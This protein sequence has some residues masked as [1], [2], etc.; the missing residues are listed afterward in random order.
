MREAAET[1][2]EAEARYRVAPVRVGSGA[3]WDEQNLR[4]YAD[5]WETEDAKEAAKQAE[6]NELAARLFEL[7]PGGAWELVTDGGRN[8]YRR[9]A[10]KLLDAGYRKVEE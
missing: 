10:Q 2:K 7:H 5:V 9:R 3:W 6:I 1:L 4:T 8:E